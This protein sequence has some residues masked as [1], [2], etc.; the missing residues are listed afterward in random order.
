MTP[1]TWDHYSRPMALT[2][3]VSFGANLGDVLSTFNATRKRL[4]SHPEMNVKR[5]SRLYQTEPL[6]SRHEE[7]PWYLNAVFEIETT[8][9]LHR[10][11]DF[12]KEIELELGRT[13]RTRWAARPIDLDILF[14]GSVIY[15][16]KQI[17]IPHPPLV[18]RKFV[19]APL[20]D[21]I[22][23]FMHPEFNL[24]LSDLLESCEDSLEVIPLDTRSKTQDLIQKPA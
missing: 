8:L 16:D 19:L 22:P 10:L 6:T 21:L 7:Q 11:F 12:L 9:T 23:D 14:F 18:K 2:T 17:S 4:E 1:T 3:Y 15:E 24:P 20:C 13:E 5:I